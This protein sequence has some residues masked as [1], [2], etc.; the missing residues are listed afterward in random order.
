MR[1]LF[2]VLGAGLLACSDPMESVSLDFRAEPIEAESVREWS[3]SQ[4]EPGYHRV[5][6]RRSVEAV[7]DCQQLDADLLRTGR[8]LTLRVRD[9]G[10]GAEDASPT[11]C[12]YT[13]VIDGVPPGQYTLRVVHSG[14]T[15]HSG[16]R[17]ILE[18]PLRIR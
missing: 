12:G 7:G 18:Q 11:S 13:A 1:A 3:V 6:V 8:D 4:I 5:R 17:V 9:S 10:V 16:A 14:M 15:S 2:A